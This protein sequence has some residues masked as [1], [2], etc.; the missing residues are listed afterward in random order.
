MLNST[1]RM[2]A[3]LKAIARRRWMPSD[4]RFVRSPERTSRA[5]APSCR[6]P[7]CWR[8][9]RKPDAK[10]PPAGLRC[11]PFENRLGGLLRGDPLRLLDFRC[12]STANVRCQW[13]QS[14]AG[15]VAET[16]TRL[17]GPPPPNVKF[18]GIA[19]SR[20][21]SW[22]TSGIGARRHSPANSERQH[23]VCHALSFRHLRT[24]ALPCE[25]G[26]SPPVTGLALSDTS[27]HSPRS[28]RLLLCRRGQC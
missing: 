20:Q 4:E 9:R 5:T 18:R 2:A 23:P 25:S 16:L 17:C 26:Q 15:I 10:L 28:C 12:G 6:C 21:R 11:E 3:V 7:R 27:R 24:A 19:D 13:E 1:V 22:P 8:A 14:L